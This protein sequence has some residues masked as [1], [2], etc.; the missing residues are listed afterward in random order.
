MTWG[1]FRGRSWS[2]GAWVGTLSSTLGRAEPPN[3]TEGSHEVRR[4]EPGTPGPGPG[5]V[6]GGAAVLGGPYK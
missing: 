5:R 6:G 4:P 2:S 1:G 3:P